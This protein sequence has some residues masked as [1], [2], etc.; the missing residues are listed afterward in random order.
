MKKILV[1]FFFF[2]SFPSFSQIIDIAP[3]ANGINTPVEITNAG[4][5]R[6]FVVE[7]AGNIRIINPDGSINAENFLTIPNEIIMTGDERGLL[8]LA[9]DPQFATNGYFYV[10][11]TG[12]PL[13]DITVARYSRDPENPNLALP[14]SGLTILTIPHPLGVHNGGTLRFGPD[15][16]LYLGVGDGAIPQTN[17]QD[18]H[19]NLG[20]MLRI[21]VSNATESVPYTIPPGNPFVG[22][23]GNDE[24]WAIGLRNPWKFSFNRLTGNLWIADVGEANVEEINHVGST[25]AGL[26]YGW[27]CY[28]GTA[29]FLDCGLPTSVLTFPLTTYNH[30]IDRC[31]IIGGYVYTGTA[32]PELQNKYFFADLCANAIFAADVTTGNITSS[33]TF[34]GELLYFMTLGEDASG[35]LY[36]AGSG[37]VI[38]KIIDATLN[39]IGFNKLAF[40]ILPNPASSQVSIK[41]NNNNYPAE[42][43]IIDVSG[44]LLLSQSLHSESDAITLGLLQ[45]GIYVVTVKDNSGAVAT[46]K[47]AID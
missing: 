25:Q 9:F 22:V 26:N 4:D 13:G 43:S 8:G 11:Y 19:L 44:K 28:E 10:C 31:S 46:S 23:D 41:L 20:K 30:A 15:G 39:T 21:D 35:Q 29:S 42:A 24:I 45:D 37:G 47:L 38:Y 1:L 40:T 2:A 34:P 7:W 12:L 27:S 14:G 32:Y 3:F 17:A 16:Y 6:L 33:A 36:V 18:I 5:D